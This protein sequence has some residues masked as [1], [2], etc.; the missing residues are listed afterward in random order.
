MVVGP[1]LPDSTMTNLCREL[2]ADSAHRTASILFI[3]G[4]EDQARADLAREAGA[5]EALLRPLDEMSL[6]QTVGRLANVAARRRARLLVRVEL[7]VQH[8]S[9]FCVGFTHNISASG[10]LLE[11]DR[12]LELGQQLTL[13]FFVPGL[14]EEVAV[15][16]EVVRV[17]RQSG[18]VSVV[19]V[20]FDNLGAR[21]G[22]AIETFVRDQVG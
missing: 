8:R 16:A 6:F 17:Q 12:A 1:D 3:G 2:R 7:E 5:N 21:F 11:A 18:G 19:G 9:G 13:R 14:E 20:Q 4:P 15:T 22:E 10:M